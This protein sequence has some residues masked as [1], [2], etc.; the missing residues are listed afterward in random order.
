MTYGMLIDLK[1]CVGCHACSVA[2]KEAHGTRPGVRRSRVDRVFEGTYP[3][4]RK[5][6]YPMLCMHCETAPCVEVCPQDATYKREDGIVV[7]DKDK[8]IGCGSCQTVCPYDARHLAASED[9]YFG[10]E[11]SEYEAV[12]YET[13]PPMTMDKCTFCA[14]RI[15]AGKGEVQACVAA[16]P[17]RP[18]APLLAARATPPPRAVSLPLR[19]P[20]AGRRFVF[21]PVEM[22]CAWQR[23]RLS[24]L[25]FARMDQ[26]KA[27]GMRRSGM[28]ARYEIEEL[29]YASGYEKMYGVTDEQLAFLSRHQD[30]LRRFEVEPTYDAALDADLERLARKRDELSRHGFDAA[31]EEGSASEAFRVEFAH[32]TTALEGN[33]LTLAETAMVLERDLT[34]PGKPLHDHLEVMDADAAFTRVRKLAADGAPLSEE[35]VFDVHRLIAAHLEEADPGEYRWDMRYVTSSSMYPPPPARV[36]ELMGALLASSL[37]HP[38][39]ATAALFHLVFEDIHPFGDGN[40]R[41]GRALL[42]LMLMEAGFPPIAF[43]A[44]RESARRYYDAIAAFAGDVEHRDGTALL[45]LVIEL[46]DQELGKRLALLG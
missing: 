7:I 1:K 12:M 32:T 5:T 46:E 27:G 41:T 33:G 20:C 34:I 9:G 30:N 37:A 14:E 38:G 42:N 40:G 19:R 43:K 3:D 17:A 13:M 2:C 44:D 25:P 31:R 39:V 28:G 24:A 22:P 23:S 8:C 15:D 36:P 6:A 16:C 4:V 10:S 35:I 21:L 11:L 45:R 29:E 18:A 26:D